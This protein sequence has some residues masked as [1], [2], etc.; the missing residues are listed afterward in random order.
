MTLD[1]AEKMKAEAPGL[2]HTLI[3]ELV[4]DFFHPPCYNDRR[5]RCILLDR[6]VALGVP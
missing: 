4:Q 2:R 1:Y 6:T 5:G 3:R